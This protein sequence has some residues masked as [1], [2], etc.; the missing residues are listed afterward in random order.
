MAYAPRCRV[1]STLR[2]SISTIGLCAIKEAV[3]GKRYELSITLVGDIRSRTA[4][5]TYRAK[6]K[7][8]NVLSF[9]LDETHGEIL[10]NVPQIERECARFDLTPGGHLR[11]L[12]IH[13]CLHLKG[14]DHGGTM[15]RAETK[16][17][18]KFNIR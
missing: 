17:L 13:G 12:L 14:Y 11:F 3:L 18:N 2:R 8:T 9:P 15:E 1:H 16:L 7:P 10:L 5:R 6:D 4:N